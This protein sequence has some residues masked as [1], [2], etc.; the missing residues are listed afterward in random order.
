MHLEYAWG[1]E[2]NLESYHNTF[3]VSADWHALFNHPEPK[4]MLIPQLDTLEKLQQITSFGKRRRKSMND[5][6]RIASDL[7]K[8]FENKEFSYHL[9]STRTLHEPICRYEGPNANRK[10]H[11]TPFTTLGPV[12]SHIHPHYVVVNA[13]QQIGRLTW[14]EP[15]ESRIAANSGETVQTAILRR[16]LVQDLYEAWTQTDIPS[17]FLG[18]RSS[19]HWK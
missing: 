2:L 12:T 10:M 8:Y 15:V 9:L 6:A 4:W 14:A 5:R 3:L 1:G 16:I 17:E 7:R 13:A 19:Q 18:W 11:T